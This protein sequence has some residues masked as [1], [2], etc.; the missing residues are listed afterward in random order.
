M[1]MKNQI[2][3]VKKFYQE[4]QIKVWLGIII[5][6]V[7]LF[8]AFKQNQSQK[9]NIVNVSKIDLK[10]TVLATGQ[11]TSKT[12]L[13]LS[14][15]SSGLVSV[16]P[17]SV[18]DKVYKGQL[19]ASLD[20]R[21]QYAA[22]SDAKANYQKV[23]EGSSSEEIAVA[24]AAL[25]TAKTNLD[26]AKNTQDS[27]VETSRRNLFNADLTPVLS[28]GTNGS[29]SSI[30]TVTGTY[31]GTEEGSYNIVSYVTGTSGYFSFSGLENGVGVISATAPQAFGKKGLYIQFPSNFSS[32]AGVSWTLNIPNKQSVSYLNALNNYQNALKNHDSAI[33]SAQALVVEKQADLDLKQ[34]AARDSDIAIAQAKVDQAKAVYDGTV[35]YAPADGT[36]AHVDTKIGEHADAQKEIMVLQ[37]V[38]N[39]YV[40]AN[41]NET[42]IAKIALDQPVSMTLDAFGP[43]TIFKGKIVHIDPSSTTQDGVV[44]YVIKA[45]I[46]LECKNSQDCAKTTDIIRPGMNAN[47]TI[48]SGDWPNV[49]AIPK[50]AITTKDGVSQVFLV[51]NDKDEYKTQTVTTGAL[52]DGNMMEIKSGLSVGDKIA[53]IQ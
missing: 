21:D 30:P 39:L 17:V 37:D 20:N 19:L 1:N 2:E 40:E 4:N 6:I 28:S 16:L 26:N 36:I 3:S 38:S 52:G 42:S 31:T 34:S 25:E 43:E 9:L 12:D 47:M 14:F 46:E 48:T 27:L 50:T 35:L 32:N 8:F 11:V 13:N 15:L 51:I 24:K 5:I 44:N 7:V 45:S 53:V 41:V 49:L 23:I 10:Q 29:A 22:L 18:G 33:A